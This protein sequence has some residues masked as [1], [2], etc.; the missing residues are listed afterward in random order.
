MRRVRLH[1]TQ[2]TQL[3][4]TKIKRSVIWCFGMRVLI[5]GFEPNDD[6]LNASELV[7]VSLRDNPTQEIRQYVDCIDFK[8]LPGNT[9]TLGHVVDETIKAFSP[10]ICI[11]I[12][13]A[14]GYN[15]IAIERM[16]K[17]L[18]YFVTLDAAGNAPKGKPIVPNA[19]IAYWDCLADPED[20]V[21]LLESHNIPTR[22]SNDGGTHLCNQVFYHFLH[23]KEIHNSD[24]K[25]GFIHIPALPEQVIKY[26]SESPFM[27]IEMT[28]KAL[29]LIISRQ[30]Q[31]VDP[32]LYV[33]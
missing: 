25:V 1:S 26:W 17:N 28:R 22:I 19:P 24:M 13:Q 6:G 27:P 12:G 23:W 14:R 15:K 16:A 31:S 30:I 18:R 8:I 11:G 3:N 7:V 9:N 4:K 32:S 33:G 2:P 29:S 5:T 20:L 21:S 10:D